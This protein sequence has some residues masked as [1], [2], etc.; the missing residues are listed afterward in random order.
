ML[1]VSDL[2][3]KDVKLLMTSTGIR[4]GSI[5]ALR[6]KHLEKINNIYELILYEGS[7]SQYFTFCSPESAY[8]IDAYLQYRT[9]NCESLT[10]D[11]VLIRKQFDIIDLEQIIKKLK[12]THRTRVKEESWRWCALSIIYSTRLY[13]H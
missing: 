3:A 8:Y 13:Q 4:I 10:K 11:S 9:K 12:P 6:L 7:T 1:D 5:P 2:R